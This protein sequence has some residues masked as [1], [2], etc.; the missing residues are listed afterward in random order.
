MNEAMFMQVIEEIDD[1]L[2]HGF[3]DELLAMENVDIYALFGRRSKELHGFKIVKD[4]KIRHIYFHDI[5]R[6]EQIIK[7]M[8]GK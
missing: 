5:D 1:Y 4:D 2:L 3:D 7:D 6:M 8:Q